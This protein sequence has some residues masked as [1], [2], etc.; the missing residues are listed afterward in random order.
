MHWVLL[1]SFQQWLPRG[2][3]IGDGTWKDELK[4][5]QANR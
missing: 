3:D 1:G 5:L 4:A 2:S